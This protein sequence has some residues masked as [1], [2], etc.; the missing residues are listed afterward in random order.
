MPKNIGDVLG[1]YDK[2]LIPELNSGQLAMLIRA[3]FL[4]DVKSYSKVQGQP[5]FTDELE[6]AILELID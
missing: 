6:H 5:I 1:S 2:I 4:V 3:R